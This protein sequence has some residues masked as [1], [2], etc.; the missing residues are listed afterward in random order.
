MSWLLSVPV[1]F[2]RTVVAVIAAV[3]L[4]FGV[5]ATE[6]RVNSSVDNLLPQDDPER[7][8][9]EEVKRVFGSDEAGVIAVFAD[10][11]FAPSTI[12]KIA[13]LSK[14]LTAVEGVREVLSLATVK[15]VE[16]DQWG[17]VRV[18]RLLHEPPATVE[19]ARAFR[20]RLLSNRF[21]AGKL[22]SP[23][24][25]ATGI[26]I[27][28]DSL[29]DEEFIEQDIDG[30]IRAVVARYEG[31][32][33]FA[34]TGIQTL[35]VNSARMMEEDLQRFLP[36]SLVVVIFVLGWA[37]R[38]VRG[39]VLPLLAVLVGVV[40]TTG[41]MVLTE[42]AIN[43]GTL[44]L[45]PLLMAI[46][47][48]YAIHVVSRYY[49]ELAPGRDRV[50]VAEATMVHVRLPIF[51]A[52]LTTLI[53]FASLILSEIPAIRDFGIFAVFGIAAIFLVSITL[54]PALL[55]L[56]PEARRGRSN[57]HRNDWVTAVLQRMALL[58]I[59]RRRTV[60]LVA[61]L[62]CVV[63]A[64]GLHR[65]RVETDYIQFLDPDT[66]IRMENTRIS[67]RLGGT[68]P[69]YIVIDGEG[70]GA[71]GRLSVLAAI[72]DLQ[73][74]MAE[75]PKVDGSLSIVD[76]V[77]IMRE[78]LNPD[79]ARG[80]PDTQ[81]EVNQ[82]LLFVDSK[83]LAPILTKDMSRAN[84]IVG[85]R[86]SGS[87]EVSEFVARV[88]DF[89]HR[90]FQ[91][92][93]EVHVTG[94]MVL[95]NRSAD[96]LARGQLY[97]LLQVLGVLL[98]LMS[99]LFLSLRAGILS[100]VPNILPV[101]VLMALMGFTGITLNISTSMIAVIAIG[102]AIDDTIH[103]LSEFN[104]QTRETGSEEQ[105]IVR[106]GRSV[107]LAMVV[108]SVALTAGFLVVCVSNFLPIR[109][110]GI[111]ASATMVVAL[112]FDLLVTPALVMTAHIVTVW[113]LLYTRL[114]TQPHKEI[115]LFAGL[116]PFQAKIVVLM[117]Q[118]ARASPGDMLTR[119]G[120]FREELYVL[121]NGRVEVRRSEDN[122]VIRVCGR[123]E[124]IG[125]MGLM[126]HKPRSADIVVAEE[127][128]Y[129][130]LDAASVARIQRR[131]PRIAAVVFQNLTKILSDRLENTTNQLVLAIQAGKRR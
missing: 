119:Q 79:V 87:A 25:T 111:L 14:D 105:A 37:F 53:G 32:E 20:E 28:F 90:R 129:I 4:G 27:L 118:L 52:A 106:A 81:A 116:R 64:F 73:D 76:Y 26:A 98:L 69:I 1:R 124:V 86:L 93:V 15:G 7:I 99:T 34:I 46:G 30:Q 41:L 24:E 131:Y 96:A 80:L 102:I 66:P 113:D 50:A 72:K 17:A 74:F 120:E 85:T 107:G 110:F 88:E 33:E 19:E 71:I 44:V 10:D 123:G 84:V 54:I 38:T 21:Y 35:K 67:E 18:G 92:G 100:L 40:W 75:I 9:Y 12:A 101:F 94:T 108:T 70:E 97:G 13:A 58:A 68:Q 89:A 128:E 121:L 125:E 36:I 82:L 6:I 78:I 83:E 91:R 16:T 39:I 2:P 95:L 51:I 122:R 109:H 56:L 5:V 112:V 130:V 29:T 104:R 115:P 11:V 31:P 57:Y 127:T 117:G 114:G 43:L 61:F 126:R 62:V 49:Q 8:Y 42:E 47:I 23:D 48:A 63:S 55:V 45:P 77:T 59:R 65:I 60:L 22:V 3:T 103:Y